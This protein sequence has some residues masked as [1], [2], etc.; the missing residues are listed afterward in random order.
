[1]RRDLN[2]Q[3][4]MQGECLLC[5]LIRTYSSSVLIREYVMKPSLLPLGVCPVVAAPGKDGSCGRSVLSA[6]NDLGLGAEIVCN[7]EKQC[8]R[9][10][11]GCVS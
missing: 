6:F 11:F 5:F 4:W 10:V 3:L 7:Q 9:A 1:M 2:W 8:T